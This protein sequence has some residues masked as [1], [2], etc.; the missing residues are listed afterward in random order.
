MAAAAA[1]LELSV[2]TSLRHRHAY[3]SAL[4]FSLRRDTA[5][6]RMLWE[7][8]TRAHI[9]S[10]LADWVVV[11]CFLLPYTHTQTRARARAV[12]YFL[13]LY[14]RQPLATVLC[15]NVADFYFCSALFTA[16]VR[17]SLPPSPFFSGVISLR[18]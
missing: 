14:T 6:A 13:F 3:S 18:M 11:R 4:Y 2:S 1:A 9:G 15:V 16:H 12:F 10:L 17:L 5:V 8:H 7:R